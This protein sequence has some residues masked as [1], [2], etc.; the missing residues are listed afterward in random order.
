MQGS[1]CRNNRLLGNR[2][3]AAVP[4]TTVVRANNLTMGLLTLTVSP[5]V[6]VSK[7]VSVRMKSALSISIVR[8]KI[9]STSSYSVIVI[10]SPLDTVAV[11][12]MVTVMGGSVIVA[13][14]VVV[15]DTE[16]VVFSNR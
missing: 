10:S 6:I 14:S 11:E 4:G 3:G 1:S 15:I 13:T 8:V 5:L 2:E 9:S 16:I 12:S 7:Y